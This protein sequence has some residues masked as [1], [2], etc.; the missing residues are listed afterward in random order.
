MPEEVAA[1]AN[2]IDS[3]K[4][5]LLDVLMEISKGRFTKM[6]N[7]GLV[8]LGLRDLQSSDICCFRQRSND[9]TFF[10]QLFVLLLCRIHLQ[11]EDAHYA[12]HGYKE[13]VLHLPPLRPPEWIWYGR[14]R[15]LHCITKRS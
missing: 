8:G 12:M 10:I 5:A 2:W 15:R 1:V 4:K 7:S 13:A 9:A 3:N 6:T 14:T 11:Q